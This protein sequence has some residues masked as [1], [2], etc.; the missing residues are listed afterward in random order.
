MINNCQIQIKKM[1]Q[2]SNCFLKFKDKNKNLINIQSN[3]IKV[4]FQAKLKTLST[5]EIKYFSNMIM[6]YLNYIQK[7]PS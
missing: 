7:R 6:L 2:K 4:L 5:K 1:C 3:Y